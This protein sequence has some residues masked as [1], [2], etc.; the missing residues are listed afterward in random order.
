MSFTREEVHRFR[1]SS[2][3]WGLGFLLVDGTIYL[4]ALY[5]AVTSAFWLSQ[6]CWSIVAGFVAT[7]LFIIAHDAC[8]HSLTPNRA[9][10][11][12]AGT[13]AFFPMLHSYSLWRYTHNIL[14]HL[15]T[16]RRGKD[17]VW[18]PLSPL[19]YRALSSWG[20]AKYRFFRS[21]FGHFF[22]YTFEI[23]FRLRLFPWRRYL[24]EVRREYWVDFGLVVGYVAAMSAALIALRTWHLGVP[25]L[26]TAYWVHPV[27]LGVVLPFLIGNMVTS[28]SEFLQ[29]TQPEIHWSWNPPEDKFEIHQARVTVHIEHSPAVDW[30]V[31]W[32]RDHTA[33]HMQPA[34]P[35]YRLRQAQEIV[36]ERHA[37]KVVRYHY[38]LR[39]ISKVIRA[40]KLYDDE[41]GCWVDFD[42][43]PTSQSRQP[44]KPRES[45]VNESAN[46]MSSAPVVA[47]VSG[48]PHG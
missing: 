33:H 47:C 2:Y 5:G 1:V 9:L 45:A 25:F 34:I 23:W 39:E 24:D 38:G 8:H 40:C 11:R 41:L 46:Q 36:E 43:H 32:I 3:A 19:E 20:R 29:H 31:H 6:L 26:S 7:G 10:N 22:Y 14:H 27:L 48:G 35:L 18:E 16:N 15:Y 12:V 44:G 37:D 13:L 17:Y 28:H 30:I 21:W 42:S 4:V